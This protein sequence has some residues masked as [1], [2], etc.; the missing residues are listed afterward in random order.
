[1]KTVKFSAMSIAAGSGLKIQFEN[2]IESPD[3]RQSHNCYMSHIIYKI[4]VRI[5]ETNLKSELSIHNFGTT[6][7]VENRTGLFNLTFK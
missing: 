5:D 1:M 6:F 2:R 3:Y 7:S 4:W